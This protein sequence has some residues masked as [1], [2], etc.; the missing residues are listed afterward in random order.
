MSIRI[1]KIIMILF[2]FRNFDFG[3]ADANEIVLLL[4]FHFMETSRD[5]EIG[6]RMIVERI[7][8]GDIV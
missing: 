2:P 5:V 6:I 8:A 7:V 4:V 1:V 3:S